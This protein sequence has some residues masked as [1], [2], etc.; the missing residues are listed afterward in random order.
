[1]AALAGRLAASVAAGGTCAAADGPF[2]IGDCIGGV[3]AIG[4]TAWTAY[5]LYRVTKTLPSEMQN[6]MTSM[7]DNYQR[8]IKHKALERAK[9]VLQLCKESSIE[10]SKAMEE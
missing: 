6:Y 2:P 4:G 1:M 10:I 8:D 5:D 3:V 7:I 9:A